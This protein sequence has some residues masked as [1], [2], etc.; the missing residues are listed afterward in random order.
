MRSAD[1]DVRERS[2]LAAVK[3]ALARETPGHSATDDVVQATA[4]RPCPGVGRGGRSSPVQFQ[5]SQAGIAFVSPRSAPIGPDSGQ[6]FRTLS[7]SALDPAANDL[8][9][10][11]ADFWAD[12]WLGHRRS[13][14]GVVKTKFSRPDVGTCMRD[15]TA[16]N[17]AAP[18][19]SEREMDIIGV[20]LASPPPTDDVAGG[21]RDPG[22]RSGQSPES[23]TSFRRAR[24]VVVGGQGHRSRRAAADARGRPGDVAFV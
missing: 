15:V 2:R 13:A 14:P 5:L 7:V 20:I 6:L 1:V 19:R 10:A 11:C 8:P 18:A 9:K 24:T 16:D 21:G 4:R 22:R 17:S 23:E 3:S 12:G